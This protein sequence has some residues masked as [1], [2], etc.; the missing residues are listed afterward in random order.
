MTVKDNKG[1]VNNMI[2]TRYIVAI[3][4]GSNSFHMVIAKEHAGQL[5]VVERQKQRTNLSMGLNENNQL[6]TASIDRA[7][8][9]LKEFGR[10]FSRLPQSNIRIV[11]TQSLRKAI[12][13][14]EFIKAAFKVLPYP[15]EVI[16]G[17]TQAQL[18]FEGVAHTHAIVERTLVIDIGGASTEFITGQ[19]FDAALTCSLALGSSQ[20]RRQCFY[21][22]EITQS[23]FDNAN[24]VVSQQL[25]AVAERYRKFGWKKVLGASG[26]IKLVSQCLEQLF[27]STIITPKALNR[28]QKKLIN[29]GHI[30]NITLHNFDHE[31]R[32]LLPSSV[33]ILKNICQQFSITEIQYCS[34]ALREGV[35]YSLSESIHDSNIRRQTVE[36]MTRFYH[37][38]IQYSRRVTNQLCTF[39]EQLPPAQKL[40]PQEWTCLT[41][42]AQLHE[43]GLAI[44]TK[45][46]QRHSAYIIEHSDMLG[47]NDNEKTLIIALVRYHRAAI[48]KH[49]QL[50]NIE[51]TR[52][53]ILLSM[54]RLAIICTR[55]RIHSAPIPLKITVKNHFIVGEA[56]P[57][58]YESNGLIDDLNQE[59]EQLLNTGFVLDKR[60]ETVI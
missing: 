27:G 42:A 21:Q 7:M 25:L 11:A 12:N 1:K 43:I 17:D 13:R 5:T 45:Q 46:R 36:S 50:F 53:T 3:D 20:L 30:D 35:L 40:S 29:W 6:S 56:P 26:S 33:C 16:D 8:L 44:N 37:T 10:S 4:L 47:F 51:N 18:I 15:I 52:F 41:F 22:P 39:V 14:S 31:K 38:D 59:K 60:G 54:F 57:S 19:H 2:D 24:D 28:L 32:L 23:Q 48:I 55:G 49:P 34:A 9:C 58:L